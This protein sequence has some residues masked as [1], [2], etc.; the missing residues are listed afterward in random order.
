MISS[1]IC[2]HIPWCRLLPVCHLCDIYFDL[3][4]PVY[5]WNPLFP[6]MV[7]TVISRISTIPLFS[8]SVLKLHT[9]LILVFSKSFQEACSLSLFSSYLALQ[10]RAVRVFFKLHFS[11]IFF[12]TS[13]LSLLRIHLSQTTPS[14]RVVFWHTFNGVL[15]F[16]APVLPT[17]LCS[18][19][20]LPP[21][22]SPENMLIWFHLSLPFPPYVRLHK[23][24]SRASW[25]PATYIFESFPGVER[26][27]QKD[28]KKRPKKRREKSTRKN[29]KK[30]EKKINKTKQNPFNDPVERD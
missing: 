8:L 28:T 26:S 7:S 3:N 30:Q 25:P 14:W 16:V 2:R 20:F 10:A 13:L 11:V 27:Q 17:F 6:L 12:S 15:H 21:F 1:A 9:H 19:P 5:H 22:P 18:P 29:G 24:Q 4:L 23:P